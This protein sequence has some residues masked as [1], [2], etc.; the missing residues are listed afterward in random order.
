M[1]QSDLITRCLNHS[2]AAKFP[3][4]SRQDI[5]DAEHDLG[6]PLPSFLCDLYLRIGNGGFGPRGGL[7]GLND[8]GM[9]IEGFHLVSGHQIML[10]RETQN[11]TPY[12]WPER[13]I[14]ITNINN[15]LWTALDCSTTS[16][17]VLRL[18]MNDYDFNEQ[19]FEEALELEASSLESW[20]EAWLDGKIREENYYT[21]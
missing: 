8:N 2:G 20:F 4:V 19:R 13:I 11:P 3:P 21:R 9:L 15:R 12:P 16:G 14:L 6:F 17:P 7:L 1:T 5:T 18:D 10:D